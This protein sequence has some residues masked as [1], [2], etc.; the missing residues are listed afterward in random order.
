MLLFCAGSSTLAPEVAAMFLE[1]RRASAKPVYLSWLSPPPGTT[2]G[3]AGRGI[4]AFNEDVRAIRAAAAIARH[5]E[6]LRHRIVQ[7][8]ELRREFPWRDFVGRD[9]AVVA[10]NVVAQILAAAGLPVAPG[11]TATTPEETVRAAE[12]IGFPVAIKAI[13]PSITH[14]AAAGLVALN[15][16]TPEAA[17]RTDRA[18]RARAAALGAALDGLWVQQMVA[19]GHELLVSALRDAE[20]GVLVG[21]GMGGGQ[22]EI[23]DDAVF[24]R[25]P[26]D[27]EGAFD[28]L[29]RLR[30]LR[31]LPRLMPPEGLA[32]AA[33]FIARFSALVAGAPWPDFTLEIN[34]LKVGKQGALAVDGLLVLK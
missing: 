32:Q 26:I 15:I 9:S 16:D 18:F 30:T 33:D 34:P 20:F 14:R 19:D 4:I 27:A 23:I 5:A 24:T 8:P 17:A 6:D 12:E 7:R 1:V 25:A 31:R 10:E 2:E 22:T 29:G 21:C 13:S 3:L 11:R 28:L